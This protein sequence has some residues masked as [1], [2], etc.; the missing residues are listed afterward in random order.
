MVRLSKDLNAAAAT[1]LVLMLLGRGDSYGYEIIQRVRE[2]SD[3]ALEWDEGML[4]PLLHRLERKGFIEGYDGLSA[5]GRKRR[6]Y[7][8]QTE[9]ADELSNSRAGFAA[10]ARMLDGSGDTTTL[11]GASV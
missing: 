3:G 9:G 5:T 6:Y 4:Y 10:I 1:P 11:G 2:L 8:L 7:R